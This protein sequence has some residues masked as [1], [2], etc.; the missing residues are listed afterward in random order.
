MRLH[1][2]LN[3]DKPAGMTSHDVVAKIRR[4]VG[5]KRVGHGGTLDPAATGILPMALGEATKLISYLVEGRK[6]YQATVR[7]GSTTT[8]DDAEGVV[9]EVRPVPQLTPAHIEAALESFIGQIA[10]VPPMYS[11][12]QVGGQRMYD[13]ARRGETVALAPRLVEIHSI[14]LRSWHSPDLVLD[15]VCGKGTY[16]RSL[17]RD[18]G[19]ALGC[20]AHLAALRRTQV[21]PLN[22]DSAVPLTRL[23]AE[24]DQLKQQILPPETAI[25]DWPRV[26][27]DAA[28]T[29]RIRHGLP[30]RLNSPGEQ[31]RVHDPDGLLLALVRRV[32]TGWQPFRVF[33]WA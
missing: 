31:A 32:D 3:I 21:G 26:D 7:L 16:I 10:Q 29:Q 28:I 6:A 24:P 8:T 30:V 4:L 15:V 12:I 5:Q 23:L 25:V 19:A 2:F 11:A 17:A 14:A 27:V 18:L 33:S 22:L 1:G 20:G 13:L 9:R